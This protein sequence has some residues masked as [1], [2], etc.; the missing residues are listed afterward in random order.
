[1]ATVNNQA[2]QPTSTLA[3][4]P[5]PFVLERGH[6]LHAH[7][8]FNQRPAYDRRQRGLCGGFRSPATLDL[9][10]TGASCSPE[11]IVVVQAG[12]HNI[13]TGASR[14]VRPVAAALFVHVHH[15]RVG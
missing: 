15:S 8:R 1:M 6:S 2:Q 11:L 5:V 7:S 10:L 12:V 4:V 13:D 3:V 14:Q 9:A